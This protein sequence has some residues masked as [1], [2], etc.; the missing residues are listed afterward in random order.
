MSVQ[1]VQVKGIETHL[2]IKKHQRLNT[3]PIGIPKAVGSCSLGSAE[4][5]LSWTCHP[6]LAKGTPREW[7]FS[8]KY[9]GSMDV[10]SPTKDFRIG[11]VPSLY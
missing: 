4:S 1:F 3:N 11:I 2:K 10:T 8:P 6:D 7:P 5:R 9:L